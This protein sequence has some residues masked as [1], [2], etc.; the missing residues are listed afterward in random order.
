MCGN[1]ELTSRIDCLSLNAEHTFLARRQAYQQRQK[2]VGGMY[3]N[4]ITAENEV[5]QDQEEPGGSR[6]TGLSSAADPADHSEDLTRSFVRLS[7]Q[8]TCPLDRLS[9]YEAALW[10]QACQIL[11]TLQCFNRRKPWEKRLLR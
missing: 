11:W 1:R 5:H 2:V 6:E 8:P 3:R 9:R 4:A 7:N 10:R